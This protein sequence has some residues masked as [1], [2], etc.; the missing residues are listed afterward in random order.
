MPLFDFLLLARH[1]LDAVR[2]VAA[3]VPEEAHE[4]HGGDGRASCGG[5]AVAA[6]TDAVEQPIEKH[7]GGEHRAGGCEPVAPA[8][9]DRLARVEPKDTDA[10]GRRRPGADAP[11]VDGGEVLVELV[12]EGGLFGGVGLIEVGGGFCNEMLNPVGHE[13]ELPP[14]L[15]ERGSQH[16]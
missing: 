6:A 16:G 13:E 14:D 9:V 3:N 1:G 2:V 11:T 10:D 7:G 4:A 15:G 5:R 12:N 8:G